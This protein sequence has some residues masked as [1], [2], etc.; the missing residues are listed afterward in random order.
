VE[1]R[2]LWQAVLGELEVSVSR[3]NFATWFKHT[4]IINNEDGHVIVAVPNIFTKEWLEK[5][6]HQDIKSAL[7]RLSTGVRSVEYKVT[8]AAEAA[9]DK[10]PAKPTSEASVSSPFSLSAPAAATA[11]ATARTELNSRYTFDN[12][13]VGSSNEMAYA[14]ARAVAKFPGTKYNPLFIYGG[15][16]LGKTHLVQAV[17]H[18]MSQEGRKV[19]YVT[20]EEFTN[21][22]LAALQR[23]KTDY[24]K[25]KHRDVDVLIIDDVQ[26]LGGKERTQEEFFHIFN[27]LHQANKQIILSADKPPKAIAGIEERLRS[28][29]EWGMTADIQSPDY[30]TRAAILQ[31]KAA[32]QGVMLP[33]EVVEFMARGV[34]QNIR[35]LEG[36]LT[37][38]VAQ[39]EFRGLEPNIAAATGILGQIAASRPRVKPITA[40]QVLDKTAA[41]YDLSVADLIGP[42]RD[43]EIVV[44]RQIAMYLMRQ[45]LSM[46]FP[47]IAACVGG[48]DHTTALH[49]VNKV[50]KQIERDENLRNEVALLRERLTIS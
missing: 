14:A 36:A 8:Q 12:F 17:G 24:F 22:F 46:S 21:E 7:S 42:K 13:I 49:S 47:K 44:P 15:V 50:V 6:Y 26:F 1:Y 9:A 11:V 25:E 35:E 40:K 4:A 16:G 18:A 48:R 37:Q 5:K 45:E 20:S 27:H 29:F 23:K 28:R 38:L 10:T 41:Y 2:G 19:R 33:M 43:K 30:E 3:A 34:G 39:C 31:A 32:A